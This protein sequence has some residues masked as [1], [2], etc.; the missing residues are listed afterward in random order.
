[1]TP[2]EAVTQLVRIIEA[3]DELF[4]EEIYNAMA[5]AGV[6]ALVADRTFKF[7]QIAWGRILLD[8]LGI[9]LDTGYI[10]VNGDG[11]EIESGLLAKEPYFVTAMNIGRQYPKGISKLAVTSS[12][13]DAVNNALQGG[14]KPEDLVMSP[15]LLFMEVPEQGGIEAGQQKLS[16]KITPAPDTAAET[17][18]KKSW[19]QKLF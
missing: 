9:T 10:C 2:E 11:K 6:P 13:I 7:T 18:T 15:V 17:T 16:A 12:E 3:R 8:G 5:E 4:E 1:M 14:S 19:W